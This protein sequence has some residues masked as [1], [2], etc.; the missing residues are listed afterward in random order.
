MAPRVIL[1]LD[2][3]AFFA[4]V[5]QH[6][7]PWLR[8]KPVFVC[9]NRHSR[10]VVATASYEARAFWV[11]TGM[12]I[13]EALAFCPQAVLVEGNPAKYAETF[14]QVGQMMERYS[15]VLE[16]Y[17]IDEAFLDLTATAARF[18]GPM[19]VAHELQREVRE[20]LGLSCSIGIGPNKLLAKLAS[21]LKKPNGMTQILPEEVD[22]V[23]EHLAIEK[24]CG[25]GPAFQAAL[26]AQGITTCGELAR[27]PV[28][29]LIAQFGP[30]AG[31]HLARLA[32]GIDESPVVP[33]EEGPAAKSMG[34]LHT[35]S[36]DARDLGVIRAVLL[37]L[38]EKVG[39][40]LRADGAAG[41]TVTLTIRV[42]D[43]TTVSRARTLDR[44]LDDGYDIYQAGCRILERMAL[45][46]PVRMV[47]ISVSGLSRAMRQQWWLPEVARRSR[48]VEACDRIND[49]FGETTVSPATLLYDPEARQHYQLKRYPL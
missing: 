31:T 38:A 22:A 35:L 3:D 17:S 46:Q 1:H 5:E 8:G 39:R 16:V 14:R 32:R 19:S 40:R 23:L 49:R 36:H 15:P 45:S 37:D 12:P 7:N 44:F 33:H 13:Q 28:E 21:S 41:R 10:T 29:R 43:F 47:G 9:G 34:H 25:I 42:H 18:G 11:T 20:R 6:A 24:L 27:V 2:M 30:S 4:S 26:N 48:L